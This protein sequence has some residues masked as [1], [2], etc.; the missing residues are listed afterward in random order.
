MPPQRPAW[1]ACR[2]A[3]LNSTAHALRSQVTDVLVAEFAPTPSGAPSPAVVATVDV[4]GN[5]QQRVI[6]PSDVDAVR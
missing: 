5:V 6:S 4:Q 2:A 1:R 3:R